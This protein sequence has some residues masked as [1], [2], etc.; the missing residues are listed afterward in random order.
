MHPELLRTTMLPRRHTLALAALGLT[1]MLAGCARER[2]LG[3]ET[4][5]Q[6][7]P[8]DAASP[9]GAAAVRA[10]AMRD[11]AEFF[12]G[13]T[14]TGVNIYVGLL[15]DELINARPGADHIDQRAFNENTFPAAAWNKFAN[16]YTQTV[17]AVRA[18]NQY[19]PA[20]ATRNRDIGQ[21][22]ALQGI[23]FNIAG[24]LFCNGVPLSTV[25]DAA[26]E[27]ATLVT[28]QQ[29]YQRAIAQADSAL[30][31]LGTAATDQN[32]R[33]LARIAKA[34]A[35]LNLNQLD[36]AAATVSAGGDGASSIAIPTGWQYQVEYSQTTLVNTIFDWM[37]N[38]ANFG[39]SDREGGNGLD[40]RTARDPR[41]NITTT[42]RLGQDGSTQVFTI[43]GYANGSA[44]T[45][46][47]SGVTARMIEAEAALRRNDVALW[48]SKLNEARADATVRSLRGIGA[49]PDVLPALTDPGSADARITLMF[50][51]RAFW[52][53]LTATRVG[54]LRRLQRQ[55]GRAASAVWPTGAY[56][57]G[58]T[59]GNDVTLTPSFAE[60]N[61]TAF[62]GCSDRNP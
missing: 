15:S 41:V 23:T 35:Q 51:E 13:T 24:E 62:A 28:T 56:F 20:G 4:P 49:S 22:Y 12:S 46:L 52:F 50:R 54:D 61:N 19:A 47:V 59:Y 58:G 30:A 25:N 10:G 6:I 53:Y 38:T 33:Y 36:A 40:Y 18:L 44:P 60:R 29:M 9:Q 42:S 39:P 26:P 45:T 16:A 1:V 11:F 7:R 14:N 17:R 2:L 55:Y 21:L 37:V 34:R 27:A 3:V 32:F 8:E 43:L 48:L 5:D 57:K 31:T